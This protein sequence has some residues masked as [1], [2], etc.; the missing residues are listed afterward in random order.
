VTV[1]VVWD[2]PG[3]PGPLCSC[4]HDE[5]E[6][7]AGGKCFKADEWSISTPQL[8]ACTEYRPE[9]DSDG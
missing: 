5:G 1:S 8:C 4:G 3:P 6:H 9:E 2:Q 7:L